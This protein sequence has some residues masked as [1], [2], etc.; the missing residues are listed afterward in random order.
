MSVETLTASI[1]RKMPDIGKWQSKFLP[2]L[3]WLLLSLRGKYNFENMSRYGELNESTYRRNYGRSFD[4]LRFN[5][6]LFE[7]VCEG[8]CFIAFDPCFISKSGKRTPGINY[9]WSGCAGKAKKGLD[10]A[11]FAAVDVNSNTAMHLVAEQTL[12]SKEYPSL[13]SYYAAVVST[14][15]E[16]LGETSSYLVADAYFSKRSFVDAVCET[17]LHV[18]SRFRDDVVLFYPY[19][20]PASKGRGRPRTFA[21]RVDVKHPDPQYFTPCV[22]EEDYTAYQGRVYAKAL[23]RWVSTVIVPD[24]LVYYKGRFQIEFLYRDAKQFTGLQDCQ[25]RD[26]AKLDFHFNAALTTVSLAKALHYY[27][28][29]ISKRKP[30]SMSSI[31]TQYFNELMLNRFFVAFGHDPNRMKNHQAFLKLRKLGSIAA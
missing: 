19:I 16:Q 3:F 20:G 1:L 12:E 30:F 25:S 21:G 11:G 7:E 22:K 8:E 15:G 10:I 4:F 6:L 18:V 13:L 26:E 24:I 9:F 2:H 29:P 5:Q 17:E 31:K 27:I 28:Q 23:K 14:H